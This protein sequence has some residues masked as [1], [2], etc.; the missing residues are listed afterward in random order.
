MQSK[1]GKVDLKKQIVVDNEKILLLAAKALVVF[2]K[3]K[4]DIDFL[5]HKIARRLFISG[6]IAC[7]SFLF[8]VYVLATAPAMC[9]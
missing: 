8:L 1:V 7:A 6:V 5:N 2:K 4:S 3:S 9:N